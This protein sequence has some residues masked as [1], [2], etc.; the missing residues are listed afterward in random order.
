M[1]EKDLNG[2]LLARKIKKQLK[3]EV[4]NFVKRCGIQPTLAI[5]MVGEDP[6]SATYIRSKQRTCK[7]VGIQSSLHNLP[8]TTSLFELGKKIKQLNQDDSI[9]GII[10]ELPLPQHIPYTDAVQFIEPSKDVDGLHPANLGM[11]YFGKPVFIPNTPHAVIKLLEEYEVPIEGK[12]LTIVGRSLAV[13]KPLY[14]LLLA[15]NAT[16][17][18]CH[19]RTRNLKSH[20]SRA[21]ILVVA[22]GKPGLI[23]GD[24]VKEGA[25]VVDVGINVTEKGLEGDVDYES[26]YP[27]CSLI[28][29][30]PGG[31]GPLT[32][33]MILQNT[34]KA[35]RLQVESCNLHPGLHR[36]K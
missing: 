19:S 7:K 20:T 4:E 32:V 28:T 3:N 2:K 12:D 8:E 27:V 1:N 16:I 15:K 9:H 17:T 34:L 6:S 14:S 33:S 23:T 18:S 29:P 24:M 26:V 21:D 35:A 31:V 30:V 11:L 10:L 22:V 25:V 36:I 5:V 13:G